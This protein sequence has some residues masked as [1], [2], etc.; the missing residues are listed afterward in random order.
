MCVTATLG[1]RAW[2]RR[3]TPS[4]RVHCG[5][6]GVHV[7]SWPTVDPEEPGLVHL[8]VGTS[9]PT[10][11]RIGAAARRKRERHDWVSHTPPHAAGH[12]SLGRRTHMVVPMSGAWVQARTASVCS[13]VCPS[14]APQKSPNLPPTMVDWGLTRSLLTRPFDVSPCT[15]LWQLESICGEEVE[16]R[17]TWTFGLLPGAPVRAGPINPY[18][19]TRRPFAR[20]RTPSSSR[21]SAA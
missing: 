9:L 8:L 10:R 3:R 16:G 15:P 11:C 14:S 1:R 17:S 20:R 21:G 18:R 5:G 19:S 6:R 2:S 12:L 13:T 4:G 7:R